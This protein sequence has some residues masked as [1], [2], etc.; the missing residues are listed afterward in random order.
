MVDFGGIAITILEA[1][2]VDAKR[3][4]GGDDVG[5]PVCARAG[6]GAVAESRARS[7]TN[8]DGKD[9]PHLLPI[10]IICNSPIPA[11][12]SRPIVIIKI[13]SSLCPR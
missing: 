11:T 10:R 12:S 8:A 3:A 13:V 9:L 2:E 6:N 5:P 7:G 1:D 4:P